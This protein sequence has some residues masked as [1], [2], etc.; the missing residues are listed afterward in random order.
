MD[1]AQTML[2]TRS[3]LDL[4]AIAVARAAG[5]APPSFYV[6]FADVRALMLALSDSAADSLMAVADAF[7][8]DWP[9]PHPN[10]WATDFV[11]AFVAAWC[12]NA[13]VLAYRNLEADRGDVAFD[14]SRVQSSLP[15]LTALTDRM[16]AAYPAGQSPRRV[17]CFAE[18]VILYAGMERLA[19]VSLVTRPGQLQ[20]HHYVAA[21]ARMIANAVAPPAASADGA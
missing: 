14:A 20:P 1:A 21:F 7:A 17:E 3:P 16:M 18:A 12:A 6:Y 5:A 11:T 2:K 10:A 15:I 19:A 9:P 8:V 4:T 13:E